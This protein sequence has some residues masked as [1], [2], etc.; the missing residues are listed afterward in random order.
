MQCPGHKRDA[1]DSK[2]NLKM[3]KTI[4]TRIPSSESKFAIIY[5]RGP[6]SILK[7]IHMPSITVIEGHSYVSL[8]QCLSNLLSIDHYP[9]NIIRIE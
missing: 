7:N 3:S 6:N 4:R 9:G 5:L 2:T 1:N 8:K